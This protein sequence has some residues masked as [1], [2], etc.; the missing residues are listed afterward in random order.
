MLV[1][2]KL[3]DDWTVKASASPASQLITRLRSLSGIKLPELLF[4]D[5]ERIERSYNWLPSRWPKK[6]NSTDADIIHLQWL[7]SETVSIKNIAQISKPRIMTMQDMWAFCGGE[8]YTE[9]NR[10]QAGYTKESRPATIKGI[11][12]DRWVWDKKVKYWNKPFP[13]VAISSWLAECVRSSE[14]FKDWQ[15]Q[16]IPNPINTDAWQPLDKTVARAAFNL[17]QDKKILLFGALGGTSNPRKGY[18]YLDEALSLVRQ[19]RNDIHLVVYGQGEPEHLPTSHFPISYMG[20]MSDP[21]AMC[22]LNNTADVLV[23]PA[24][25]EAFG[26]TASEAHACGLP[27]VAFADTGIADIVEHKATGYLATLANAEELA[28][29]ISWVLD[30]ISTGTSWQDEPIRRQARERAVNK[31]SFPIV[32]EQYKKLYEEV[33]GNT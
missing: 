10:W 13:L 23:N 2:K 8:H 20:R 9:G 22:M 26:Q 33:L 25:Q 24:I 3:S 12:P 14:L 30:E 32:G 19:S 4:D 18:A 11:D 5:E 16:V 29:G 27:V 17:P 28:I 6:L 31:F 1:N 7:N 21:V 15:V